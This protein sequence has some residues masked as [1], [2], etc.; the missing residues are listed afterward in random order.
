MANFYANVA[1]AS[2][3]DFDTC[4]DLVTELPARLMNLTD[5]GIK[6]GNPADLVV[7][8][9]QDSSFAIAELPDI[10]MGFKN[11][12]KTFERPQVILFGPSG[13]SR[14]A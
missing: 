13:P 10:V 11:G 12:R 4:L 3:A 2:V 8:D 14:C 7:L 5:Y 9:T 1:H 6:L